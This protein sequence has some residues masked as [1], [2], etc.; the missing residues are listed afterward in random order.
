MVSIDEI[1]GKKVIGKQGYDL[2][3]VKGVEADTSRWQITHLHVKLSD[4][5]ADELGFKKRFRSS[6]VCMPV[7]L[8]EA[9]G[10]VVTMSSTL[11]ELSGNSEITECKE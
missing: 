9:V 2:G 11:T 7:S 8:V 10:D 5:A 6:T 4:K 3:E 1:N